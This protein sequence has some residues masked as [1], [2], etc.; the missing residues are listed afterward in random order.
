VT[1]LKVTTPNDPTNPDVY[2]LGTTS[3]PGITSSPIVVT[4]ATINV[5]FG[6][7]ATGG[8]PFT[9]NG[10]SYEWWRISSN[11]SP[12][13]PN[14]NIVSNPS[15]GP[16]SLPGAYRIDIEGT[17]Q[18]GSS[19]SKFDNNFFFDIGIQVTTPEFGSMLAVVAFGAA[20]LLVFR[21]KFAGLSAHL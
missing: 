4:S 16:T 9:I 10:V 17:M 3:G 2:M 15:P 20:G 7:A 6:P 11:G 19:Q 1:Q 5:P 13:N 18:C 12:V 8:S 21:K 14:Q